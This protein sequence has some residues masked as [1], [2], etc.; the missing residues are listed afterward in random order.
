MKT[1]APKSYPRRRVALTPEQRRIHDAVHEEARLIAE[2]RLTGEWVYYPR[3]LPAIF[4]LLS[5]AI[6]R[7]CQLQQRGEWRGR[8]SALFEFYGK[9]YRLRRT[10]LDTFEVR[11]PSGGRLITTC[12]SPSLW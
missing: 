11:D 8:V 3:R 9:E 2:G 1:R 6:T 10:G 4:A 5:P 12:R 7:A